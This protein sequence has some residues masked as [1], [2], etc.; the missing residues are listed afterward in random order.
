MT[1]SI[2][3]QTRG[4]G[5]YFKI[6]NPTS[7]RGTRTAEGKI[8]TTLDLRD[9]AERLELKRWRASDL[10]LFVIRE[11]RAWRRKNGKWAKSKFHSEKRMATMSSSFTGP[12]PH[13]KAAYRRLPDASLFSPD[14]SA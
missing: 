13:T 7:G 1:L 10:T 14:T 3:F 12:T 4:D 2:S 9:A 8:S 6:E 5:D 11:C